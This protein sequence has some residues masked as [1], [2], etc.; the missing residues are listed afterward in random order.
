MAVKQN[1]I[2]PLKGMKLFLLVAQGCE[3]SFALARQV[4]YHVSHA[5]LQEWHS[6]SRHSVKEPGG[7]YAM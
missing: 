4:L 3:L 7:H 6:S 2:Q 5:P 1:I